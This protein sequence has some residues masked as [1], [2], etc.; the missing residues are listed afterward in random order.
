MTPEPPKRGMFDNG[1]ASMEAMGRIWGERPHWRRTMG[2]PDRTRC[3]MAFDM[4]RRQLDAHPNPRCRIPFLKE[5]VE[6]LPDCW[7]GEGGW[8]TLS[9]IKAVGATKGQMNYIQAPHDKEATTNA[10]Q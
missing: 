3:I 9:L 1:D 2:H 7:A 6:A 4:L 8:E 10:G 5:F